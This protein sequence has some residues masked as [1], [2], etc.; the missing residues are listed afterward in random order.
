M[1]FIGNKTTML[2]QIKNI[3]D[4]RGLLDKKLLFFDAFC[5]TGSVADYLKPFLNIVINDN[6]RWAVTYSYGRL[7]SQT[8]KFQGLRFDPFEFLNDNCS[9]RNGFFTKNYSPSNSSRMYFSVANAGRIDYFRWQIEEWEKA[10]LLTKNEYNYLLACLVESVSNV[11]NTAGVYG[12]FLKKWDN[13]ALKPIQFCHVD[14]INYPCN[15]VVTHCSKVEDIIS[16]VD[17]DIIYLDPPYTQ[18]QYGTQYHLLETLILDDNPTISKTTGS[19]PTS[20][21]RSD[22]SKDI[23]CHILFDKVISKTKAKYIIM[24]YNNDGFMSKEFIEATLKRYGNKNTYECIKVP[25]KKYQNWKSSNKQL[26]FEYLFFVEKKADD[27][28]IFESPLNYIGNK[29]KLLPTIKNLVDENKHFFFDLFGGG[30]NVG[31]NMPNPVIYYVDINFFVTELIKSF[32]TYDTYEYIS[33]VRKQIKTY[34]LKKADTQAYN[35]ARKAYNSVPQNNRDPRFLFALILYGFQQ[36]IR[37]NNDHEFNNP[38]GVR[39]FNDYVLEKMVSFSRK[40]KECNCEF[41]SNSF[42]DIEGLLNENSF[43]YLDPPY[44]LTTGSY[45]DGKRGFRGWT[46]T[47]EFELFA[48]IDR[49]NQRKIPFLLSYVVV[50]KGKT[51]SSFLEWINKNQY[52][53]LELG[54]ILGISGSRRMEVLVSN[55]DIQREAPFFNQTKPAKIETNRNLF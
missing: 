37:F 36:Q 55:Y 10:K 13:R 35:E 50:H 3:L 18:N 44:Q 38:V 12:A 32:K 51:N 1:R 20:P 42:I 27:E 16:D 43:V 6:L 52:H 34:G 8:C 25:Y 5:G 46:K 39:W 45:N 41:F 53:I 48:F 22:W 49:L 23:K 30:F 28:I 26:H 4:K 7:C 31:I 15:T 47:Q 40:I 54:G 19:R 24:S 21:M 17:C 14:S 33:F 9:V 29:A 2:P 11:S